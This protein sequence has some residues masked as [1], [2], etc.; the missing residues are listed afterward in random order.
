MTIDTDRTLSATVFR[1]NTHTDQYM[2]SQSN[3]PLHLKLGLAKALIRM[4]DNLVSKT[5]DMLSDQ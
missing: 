3:H 4:A 5:D 2:N 1:I